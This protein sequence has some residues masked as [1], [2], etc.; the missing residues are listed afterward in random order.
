MADQ[1]LR[2]K[3][4]GGGGGSGLPEPQGPGLKKKC[5]WPFG[6][7][8]GLKIVGA[9]PPPTPGAMPWIR[10][11]YKRSVEGPNRNYGT[12]PMFTQV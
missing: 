12:L 9:A 7:H 6:P 2:I 10:N 4:G 1:D 5:L 8:F 3:A 11:C